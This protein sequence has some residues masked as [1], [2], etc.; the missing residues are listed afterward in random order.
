MWPTSQCAGC[1][2]CN[3]TSHLHFPS[4]Q[5]S[6]KSRQNWTANPKPITSQY[7]Q[8]Y[9]TTSTY[10]SNA[11][12]VHVPQH[13]ARAAHSAEFLLALRAQVLSHYFKHIRKSILL[14]AFKRIRKAPFC[15]QG[16]AEAY[17]TGFDPRDPGSFQEEWR[18]SLWELKD[19]AVNLL[20]SDK[21]T[22]GWCAHR[23]NIIVLQFNPFSG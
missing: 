14:E 2:A 6:S 18:F 3:D 16:K 9:L 15:P 5:P 23:L 20:S 10:V 17:L 22:S 21:L 11:V 7:R 12:N 19:E 4:T 8:H 13:S 1:S